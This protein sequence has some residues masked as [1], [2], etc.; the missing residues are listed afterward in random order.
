MNLINIKERSIQVLCGE[1]Q[2]NNMIILSGW[3]L[4]FSNPGLY[5]VYSSSFK[6]II[7]QTCN[8]LATIGEEH[9][10]FYARV[11][12]KLRILLLY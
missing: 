8:D 7:K 1:R 10:I 3:G 6:L 4:R 9:K 5:Y 11:E 2:T 12:D